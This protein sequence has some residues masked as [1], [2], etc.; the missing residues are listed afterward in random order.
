M[1]FDLDMIFMDKDFKIVSI[2]KDA[3]AN[4]YNA[5]DPNSSQ[6]YTNGNTPAKYV[7][8]I[9]SSYS[10]KINLRVGDILRMQ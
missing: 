8:E 9:N 4:S 3:K 2:I 10:D 6:I 1:N 7:L 5:Q